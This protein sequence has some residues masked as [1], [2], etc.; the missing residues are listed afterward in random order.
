MEISQEKF[1]N[2]VKD[3]IV[4]TSEKQPYIINVVILTLLDK[5]PLNYLAYRDGSNKSLL[6]YAS[7]Y[8]HHAM[9]TTLAKCNEILIDQKAITALNCSGHD[10]DT[11]SCSSDESGSESPIGSDS[12]FFA[13]YLLI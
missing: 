5:A 11:H 7:E 1:F 2:Q 4:K 6:D 8:Q 9:S 13:S 3:F 10:L 12:D